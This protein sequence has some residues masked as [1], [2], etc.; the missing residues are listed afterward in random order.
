MEIFGIVLGTF[1]G[2]L[3]LFILIFLP[4]CCRLA[5][6]RNKQNTKSNNDSKMSA[7]YSSNKTTIISSYQE[8]ADAIVT[9]DIDSTHEHHGNLQTH[10]ENTVP[11]VGVC[12][13]LKTYNDILIQH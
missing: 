11:R 12:Y 8:P 10:G 4:V 9:L 5:R 1:L 2:A 13:N 3:I 6:K 7:S